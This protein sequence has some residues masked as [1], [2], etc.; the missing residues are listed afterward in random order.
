[1]DKEQFTA[2]VL[3]ALAQLENQEDKKMRNT[4][5]KT[6]KSRT[7]VIL[8]AALVVLLGTTAVAAE[9][10]KWNEKAADIFVAEPER[11]DRLAVEQVA[12]EGGQS[13]TDNGLTITAVQTIQDSNCFYALFEVAAEDTGLVI[14][15]NWGLSLQA[16]FQCGQDPFGYM[17][18]GFIENSRQEPGNS[19]Y[20]EIFGTKHEESGED[21]SMNLKFT[22]LTGPGQK[23]VGG[24]ALIEGNWDFALA[25]HPAK[26]IRFDLNR[27]CQINGLE[28]FVKS[29]ELSPLT[30][31]LVFGGTDIKALEEKEGVN[32]DQADVLASTMLT[33]VMYEDGAFLE[34]NG[35]QLWT[36]FDEAADY[37][38]VTRFDRV[39]EPEKVSGL[40]LG[41]GEDKIPLR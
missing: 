35:T 11:Q 4:R 24:E 32:L 13:V 5:T 29:V 18:W 31:K 30:A 7:T 19:R 37:V 10:F 40:I 21:L 2:E 15:E 6:M 27:M 25:V 26:S 23:A 20:F 38:Q 14:D 34:E 3:G 22:A 36:S 17:G 28:I 33:G 39:I 12:Q 9:F 1:M 16:D 41:N 8:A